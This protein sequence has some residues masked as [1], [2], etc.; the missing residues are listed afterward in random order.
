MAWQYQAQPSVHICSE[1]QLGYWGISGQSSWKY[2]WNCWLFWSQLWAK[3]VKTNPFEAVNCAHVFA[4][5]FRFL[6]IHHK[7]RGNTKRSLLCTSVVSYNSVTGVYQDKVAENIVWLFW[8]QLWTKFV[9]TNPFEAVNCAHVFAEV[10]IFLL[11]HHKWRDNTK[12]SLLRTYAATQSWLSG[13]IV[14]T[15]CVK[16][17]CRH[18]CCGQYSRVFI[19]WS[20]IIL[21]YVRTHNGDIHAMEFS[22]CVREQERSRCAWVNNCVILKFTQVLFKFTQLYSNFTQ[23]ILLKFTQVGTQVHSSLLECYSR[24]NFE[25]SNF[26]LILILK[27]N[28]GLE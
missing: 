2:C 9:K 12:R 10:F 6:L 14:M 22:Y 16:H 15:R 7:W 8:S 19:L 13:C 18:R 21:V 23:N 5:V 20:I 11:F 17:S 1:L 28:F 26:I 3:F 4:E 25:L 24:T 27:L